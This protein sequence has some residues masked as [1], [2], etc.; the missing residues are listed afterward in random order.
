[1]SDLPPF[2]TKTS[3]G[4]SLGRS[5]QVV[6]LRGDPYVV[7]VWDGTI[8]GLGNHVVQDTVAANVLFQI[9]SISLWTDAKGIQRYIMDLEFSA[10]PGVWIRYLTMCYLSDVQQRIQ[11][12]MGC[13]IPGVSQWRETIYN[14]NFIIRN[15]T[16]VKMFVTTLL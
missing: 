12:A 4:L 7:G 11:H 9:D 8:A 6:T 13:S 3:P 10:A 5:G 16:S 15:F 1:M 14:D 2:Y